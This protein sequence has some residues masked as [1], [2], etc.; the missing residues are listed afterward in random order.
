MEVE[1]QL[2]S[3]I[4]AVIVATVLTTP[5][6]RRRPAQA[7]Y[8]DTPRKPDSIS[9]RNKAPFPRSVERTTFRA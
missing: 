4:E 5:V 2:E 3:G 9:S 7:G 8:T 1:P 6:W